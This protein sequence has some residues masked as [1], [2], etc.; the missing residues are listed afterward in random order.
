MPSSA[1]LLHMT[2]FTPKL[3]V[4]AIVAVLMLSACGFKP[5]S[6]LVLPDDLGPVMVASQDPNSRL[7]DALE[8]RLAAAGIPLK[9]AEA[10]SPLNPDPRKPVDYTGNAVLDLK[11][12]RWGD[13]PIA[14]D[15][16]GRAQENSLRY[17]VVFEVRDADGKVTLPEQTIELS[18]DYVASPTNSIGT[19]GE[20]EV[21]VREMQRDMVSSILL[22]IDTVYRRIQ[23]ESA[24]AKAKP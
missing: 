11:T 13:L 5:R 22:R 3:V 14:L 6:A 20:R 12:E 7:A 18:R 23:A 21:L 9:D 24:Q 4:P 17:A 2:K 1:T 8:R 15:G 16:Q 10:G 19:E